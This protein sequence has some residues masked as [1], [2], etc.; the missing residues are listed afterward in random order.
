MSLLDE[1]GLRRVI[2]A[3]STATHLGGSIPDPRVMDSMKEISQRYIIMAELQ[4]K[5]GEI[6]AELT[7]AESAMVTAGASSALELAAAACILRGSSLEEHSVYPLERLQPIDGPW[8]EVMQRL[9]N[10]DWTH[11][12]FIIQA[13]HR[14]SYD[15]SYR[16]VGGKLAVV[17]DENRCTPQELE[18]RISKQTA[19]IAFSAHSADRGVTL[20]KVVEIA[21]RNDVPVIVDAATG[22][23]PRSKLKTYFMDGADLVAISGGKQ[24]AGPNDT[25]LLCGKRSLIDMAKLQASPFTGIGRGAKVDRTQVLGLVTALRIFLEKSSE[26]E[27]AEFESWR[28]RAQWVANQMMDMPGVEEAK[29]HTNGPS[30]TRAYLKIGSDSPLTAYELAF[31]LRK[32]DPSIWVETYQRNQSIIGVAFDSLLEDEE[33]IIVE[34]IERLLSSH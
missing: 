26:D 22:V 23:L 33:R 13:P 28:K 31:K 29:V 5:A 6:I 17:G 30:Y 12:E 24:I 15:Y 11:N 19:A 25:G 34:E 1:L 2:N 18:N 8:R 32:G 27:E 14:N 16:A 4:E 10:T 20:D 21:H 3:C 7:G 9:P